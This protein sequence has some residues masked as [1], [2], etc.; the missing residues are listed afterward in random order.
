MLKI[1]LLPCSVRSNSST[2]TRHPP[3]NSVERSAHAPLCVLER[4]LLLRFHNF[5]S[6]TKFSWNFGENLR[7]KFMQVGD[8]AGRRGFVG[9]QTLVRHETHRLLFGILLAN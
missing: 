9:I 6:R 5:T 7:R 8:W 2:S 4:V 1:D 3:A